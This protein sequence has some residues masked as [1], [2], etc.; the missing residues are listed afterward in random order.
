RS[1]SARCRSLLEVKREALATM[2][3]VRVIA[4]IQNQ[5]GFMTSLVR[6]A[7]GPDPEAS[8]RRRCGNFKTGVRRVHFQADR[9]GIRPIESDSI[10]ESFWTTPWPNRRRHY[11]D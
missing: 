11:F 5:R 4:A 6:L 2:Q 9:C 7:L 8:V 3:T 10:W 1:S